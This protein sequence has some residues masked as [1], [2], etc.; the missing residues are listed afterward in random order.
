M[1]HD[2]LEIGD[3]LA[4]LRAAVIEFGEIAPHGLAPR[5]GG[6]GRERRL[7]LAL[8]VMRK[9]SGVTGDQLAVLRGVVDDK[10]HDHAQPAGLCRRGEIVQQAVVVAR[11]VAAKPRV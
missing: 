4:A 11:L 9:P 5:I 3:D 2:L 10:I 1:T 7:D 8:F 6:V